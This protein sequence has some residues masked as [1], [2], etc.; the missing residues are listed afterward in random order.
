MPAREPTSSDLTRRTF[1]R[2]GA[3]TVGAVAASGIGV[4]TAA[5]GGGKGGGGDKGGKG[6]GAMTNP[7]Y[8]PPTLDPGA[9]LV[10]LT[11]APGLVDLGPYNAASAWVYNGGMPGP[12]LEVSTGDTVQL[13]FQNDLP[14][15]SITHWHGMVV[16]HDNDGHPNQEVEAG[17][18]YDYAFPIVQRA[19]MN[20]YHP[21]PHE[22]TGKQVALGLAG[23]FII[24]DA[25]EAAL[26]LPAGVRELPLVIRDGDVDRE[27]TAVIYKPKSSG[28]EGKKAFVNGTLEPYVEVDNALYRLRVLNGANGRIFRFAFA[29]GRG[30]T[31]IGNDGGF[32]PAPETVTE[33]E[34]S[35]GERLDLLVDL[36]DLD[37][38]DTAMLVDRNSGWD[39]LE[40]RVVRSV[41]DTTLIPTSLPA[42]PAPLSDP[43][44]TRTFSF[45]GMGK[46]NGL[47]YAMER[48]D[49]EVPYGQTERWVLTTG[50]NAPHPVHI[51][52]TYF[53]VVSR[54]GGRGQVFPWE[55]GW[56]DT[57]LLQDGETVEILI[58]FD[59][60]H[61]DLYLMHCHK[62]E[63]EDR[64]MM[65]NFLVV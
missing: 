27:G 28:Y 19:T 32:L 39:L 51:H 33:I 52:G 54:T 22:R 62:L 42:P 38:N 26:G 1:L 11:A 2:T 47:E 6:G 23:A 31:L 40:F 7:L 58:R 60:G 17:S 48:I 16:D 20:W 13:R 4:A 24:R 15:G 45:D 50:G 12:T 65:S 46:I 63:H 36:R 29:D 49:F 18:H 55:R 56:K 34:L 21:H 25:Q 8:L 5:P 61:K 35:N 59:H 43:V 53:Q 30:M 10:T 64:G 44:R 57:V 9:G 37:K 14:E 41:N 3:L